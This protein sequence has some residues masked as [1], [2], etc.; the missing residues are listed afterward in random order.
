MANFLLSFP[1]T[2]KFRLHVAH[3]LKT[4]YPIIP[5]N[6]TQTAEGKADCLHVIIP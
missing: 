5:F 3:D 1:L 6:A 2:D 4:Y